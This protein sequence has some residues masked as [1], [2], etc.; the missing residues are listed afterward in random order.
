MERSKIVSERHVTKPVRALRLRG[1]V[2]SPETQT[3]TSDSSPK[4]RFGPETRCPS[5]ST[6]ELAKEKGFVTC[7]FA[8]Y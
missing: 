3:E 4:P 6:R 5:L 2:K 1:G 8:N 7:L